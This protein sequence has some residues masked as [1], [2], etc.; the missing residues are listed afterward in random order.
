MSMC[1]YMYVGICITEKRDIQLL[2]WISSEEGCGNIENH[3]VVL[4]VY[5]M[6]IHNILIFHHG[7]IF[8]FL[9]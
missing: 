4:H 3:D 2:I 6:Y 5:S 9:A 7:S 8:T 1:L